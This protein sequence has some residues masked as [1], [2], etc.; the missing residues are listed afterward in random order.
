ML[1][2][3]R[4]IDVVDEA[5]IKYL[6]RSILNYFLKTLRPVQTMHERLYNQMRQNQE[7]SIKPIFSPMADVAERIARERA[8]RLD[9]LVKSAYPRW[10]RQIK[11]ILI[12]KYVGKWYRIEVRHLTN[13]KVEVWKSGKRF[14]VIDF[15]L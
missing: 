2:K 11:S 10:A 15:S 8:E 5:S 7:L 6:D 13:N 1:R 12:L 9:N 14:G 4:P 3:Q